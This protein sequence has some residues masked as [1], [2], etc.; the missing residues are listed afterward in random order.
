MRSDRVVPFQDIEEHLVGSRC[1]VCGKL[2]TAG[3]KYN[4][5]IILNKGSVTVYCSNKCKESINGS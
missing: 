3:N 1:A 5:V 4:V 2:I